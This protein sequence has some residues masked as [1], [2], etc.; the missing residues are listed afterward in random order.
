[1]PFI[2]I[3]TDLLSFLQSE[4]SRAFDISLIEQRKLA[5]EF[6]KGMPFGDEVEGRSQL[7]TRDVAEVVDAMTVG[8]MRTMIASDH[9]VEFEAREI[10]QQEAAKD[11][12]ELVSWQFLRQQPGVAILR[13]GLTSGLLEKTGVFKTWV[14]R[15]ERVDEDL[16]TDLAAEDIVAAEDTGEFD[17]D[18]ATG[19]VV[20]VWRVLRRGEDL[21]YRDAAVPNEEFGFS[22][23]ARELDEADYIVHRTRYTVAEVATMFGLEPEEV[24]QFG[25][26]VGE[27]QQLS[28][29]RDGDRSYKDD[30]G[31]ATGMFRKVWIE[32][33]Y[34][35]YDFNGDG[36]AE[37]LMIQRVGTKGLSI[38]PVE[39]QPFTIWSPFP[40][41]HRIVGDSV[42]DKTMDIQRVR[43]VLLR[44]A[45]DAMY[46]A[47]APRALIDTNNMDPNT[48]DDMLSIVPGAPI[49]YSGTPPQPWQM[50][51]AAPQA[52][53]ALEFMSGERESRTGVTRHNQGLNPDTLNKTVGGMAMLQEAGAKMEEYVARNFAECVAELFE[54]K[55]R[56]MRRHGF[57]AKVRVGGQFKQ[58][59]A[60]SLPEE[61]DITIRVGLGSG[62]RDQ[63]LHHRMMVL[64]MQKEAKEIGSPLV[65]DEKLFNS[66]AGI[67]SD[68]G[69]GDVNTYF[70]DPSNP[71]N[72]TQEPQKDAATIEAEGKIA[73]AQDQQQFEQGK[74]AAQVETDRMKAEAGV[75]IARMKAENEAQL[76]RDKSAFE[77]DLALRKATFEEGLAERRML[78]EASMRQSQPDVTVPKNRPG[79]A[80]DA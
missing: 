35:R 24:Q 77:A 75:E 25:A 49:R 28:N 22:P 45:M 59:E 78:F 65:D 7:V 12:T 6:Y 67:V 4:H 50:T 5:I 42:A 14:E 20:P 58:V 17:E 26:Y 23:E 64:D 73:L 69:L 60:A 41:A 3:P 40:A 10:E 15:K 1:M 56:L 63:R 16:T 54:K 44:Q 79:G 2:D 70:N 68:A 53:T 52:F 71:E 76:A 39:D 51:F 18:P 80:L 8:I 11:A 43:S 66:A 48:I 57:S 31:G 74:A 13:S 37:R 38:Q 33:E 32:E 21:T 27:G 62:R 61:M 30:D 29:A 72:Q 19:E 34:V 36:H 46:F 47:N 55:Y 9:V